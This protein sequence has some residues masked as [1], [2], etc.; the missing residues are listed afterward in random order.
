VGD[1]ILRYQGI[2]QI[3]GNII[4]TIFRGPVDNANKRHPFSPKNLVSLLHGK[5]INVQFGGQAGW[6]SKYLIFFNHVVLISLIEGWRNGVK[7]FPKNRKIPVNGQGD[8]CWRN[9]YL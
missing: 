5:S 6:S 9:G 4:K 7:I 2:E 3:T 1:Y 8:L